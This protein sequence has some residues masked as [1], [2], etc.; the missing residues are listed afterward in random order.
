MKRSLS[1]LLVLTLITGLF[2]MPMSFADSNKDRN[3]NEFVEVADPYGEFIGNMSYEEY[4]NYIGDESFSLED[5]L[6]TPL[7]EVGIIEDKNLSFIRY[8]QSDPSWSSY[9]LLNSISN[10]IGSAGCALT[11][12]A[13]VLD[14]FGYNDNPKIVNDKLLPYQPA[15]NGDMQWLNVPK[16]YPGMTFKYSSSTTYTSLTYGLFS[17]VRGQMRLNRPVIIGFKKGTSTHFV[18]AYRFVEY[19]DPFTGESGYQI[20]IKDPASRNYIDVDDYFSAGY[21]VYRLYT[22]DD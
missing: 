21:Y 12:V 1:L 2:A 9:Q 3:V 19:E 6:V 20:Y 14:Y 18:A 13:M 15:D 16:A 7:S 11:S 22:Y 8:V 10:T 5:S 4:L 17:T